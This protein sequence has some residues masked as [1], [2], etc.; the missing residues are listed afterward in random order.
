VEEEEGMGEADR[1]ALDVATESRGKPDAGV[2]P[3][4]E[5]VRGTAF[6]RGTETE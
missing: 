1:S 6:D 2:S 3:G 5:M 4:A